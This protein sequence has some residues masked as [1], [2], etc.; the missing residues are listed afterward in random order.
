[1]IK[2]VILDC[3]GLM[4]DTERVSKESWLAF[5]NKHGYAFDDEFFIGITGVGAKEAQPQF[6]RFPGLSDHLPELQ[7]IRYEMIMSEAHDQGL[8]KKGL[9]ALLDY[10]EANDYKLC[11]GSSSR[12]DYV[13]EL[14]STLSKTYHFDFICCGDMIQNR[15]PFPD[16]FLKCV[17][18]VH[19]EPKECLVLEDSKMGIIAAHRAGCIAGFIPDLI[20][21]DDSFA[22]LIDHEF[23]S[24]DEVIP[25]LATQKHREPAQH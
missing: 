20:A 25:F 5:G 24:L 18:E 7:A 11:V 3:D 21:K 22:H 9:E 23:N 14:L 8:A 1:M 17:E 15:K 12:L 4:F 13:Q 10:L 6:D 2:C 19:L 16:I